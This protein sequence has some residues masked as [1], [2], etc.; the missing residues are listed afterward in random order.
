MLC[1]ECRKRPATVHVTKITDDQRTEMN[2]CEIC[3]RELGEVEL[4]TEPKF[5][6]QSLLAGL[7]AHEASRAERRPVAEDRC[8]NCGLTYQ[9]FTKAGRLG[10]SQCYAAFETRLEPLLRRIHGATAHTGKVPAQGARP[11]SRRDELAMLR[12]ELEMCVRREEFERAAEL[13]DRIRE[14]EQRSGE[15]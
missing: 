6:L 12:H 4:L 8:S 9:Q 3:A 11:R 5:S 7:L 15:S 10:C 1:Q 2:L 13:R 14:L